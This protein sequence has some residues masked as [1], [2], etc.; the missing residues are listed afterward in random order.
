MTSNRNWHMGDFF[1]IFHMV[2]EGPFQNQFQK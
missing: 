1:V 2:V